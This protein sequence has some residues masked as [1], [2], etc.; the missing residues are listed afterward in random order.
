MELKEGIQ[1]QAQTPDGALA[2]VAITAI[3][4]DEVI[5][6]ANHPMA[7]MKLHFYV[8]LVD[9]RDASEQEIQH[10]HV[11]GPGEHE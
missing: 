2:I 1:F 11:H 4:A 10:Q 7:G 3:E 9:V 6:D 8:E 5:V